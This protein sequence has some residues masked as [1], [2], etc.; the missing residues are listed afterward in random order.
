MNIQSGSNIR[1]ATR[2]GFIGVMVRVDNA[3][4]G[5]MVFIPFCYAVA[6]AN[7]L[8]NPVPGPFGK[9]P[10]YKFCAARVEILEVA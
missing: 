4:P 6:P 7:V 2:H 9:I 10:E 1:V 3:V 8:T 5:E